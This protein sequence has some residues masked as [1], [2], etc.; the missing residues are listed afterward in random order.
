LQVSARIASGPDPHEVIASSDATRAY[1]SNY[2]GEGSSL[3]FISVVDLTARKPLSPIDLGALHSAHGLDFQGGKLYFTAE[4]N[5]VI[6]SFDP[7][8]QRIDWVLGTG[9]DR[10]HMVLVARDL[11]H[12]YTSNVASGTISIMHTEMR[13]QGPTP[14]GSRKVWEVTNIPAG[15]GAEGFDVSPDARQLWA[16]NAQDGTITVIDVAT[17][18]A[19]ETFP[20]PVKGANRLKF[21]LDGRQVLVSGLGSFG[22]GQESGSNN[23]VVLDARSHRLTKAFQLGGGSAGILMDPSGTRA[24][25]AVNQGGKVVVIDLRTLQVSGQIPANQ[26]DGMAWAQAAQTARGVAH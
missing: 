2:G 6:G 12:I 7:V 14:G 21:S 15:R 26:P 11:E 10:T 22:P 3:N 5:K 24:F 9:Q 18:K 1:I 20:V 16:A 4:T 13:G 25:V 17:M 23:L 8:S 19:L